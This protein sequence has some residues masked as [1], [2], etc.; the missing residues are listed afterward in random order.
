[1]YIKSIALVS[2]LVGLIMVSTLILGSVLAPESSQ[3]IQY[4]YGDVIYSGNIT[5]TASKW[6][7]DFFFIHR[8]LRPSSEVMIAFSA[9]TSAHVY[10]LTQD[11]YRS[12]ITGESYNIKYDSGRVGSGVF[13]FTIDSASNWYFGFYLPRTAFFCG[14]FATDVFFDQAIISYNITISAL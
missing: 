2:G 5:L 7:D 4:F 12:L 9:D 8:S 1:M 13:T 3:N 11:D 14:G 6:H 10:F